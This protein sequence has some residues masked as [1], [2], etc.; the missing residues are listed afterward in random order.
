MKVKF[1]VNLRGL[2]ELMKSPEMVAA[3][4][5]AGQAVMQSAGEGYK[6]D[7]IVNTAKSEFIAITR[8]EAESKEAVRDCLRNNRLLTALSGSGLRMTKG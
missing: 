3:L 1:K 2:N 8:I 6:M 7:T 4:E 5:N